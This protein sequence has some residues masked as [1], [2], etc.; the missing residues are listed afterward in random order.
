[1]PRGRAV[2][3]AR[4]PSTWTDTPRDGLPTTF[5]DEEKADFVAAGVPV[6]ELERQCIYWALSIGDQQ[7]ALQR[8]NGDPNRWNTELTKQMIRSID[9]ALP[10]RSGVAGG[11]NDLDLWWNRVGE[12]CRAE[13]TRMC[14]RIHQ[15]TAQERALFFEHCVAA[16]TA[17]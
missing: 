13:L 16:R 15:L 8:A 14:T 9:G 7:I 3:F 12:R 4:F 17:G 2:F 11:P 6:P 10:D 1:V 5:D